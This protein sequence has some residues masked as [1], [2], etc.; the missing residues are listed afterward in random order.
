MHFV[1]QRHTLHYSCPSFHSLNLVVLIFNDECLTRFKNF[2]S[3]ILLPHYSL[4]CSFTASFIF[5]E[6]NCKKNTKTKYKVGCLTKHINTHSHVV[7][8][9]WYLSRSAS[10]FSLF[11]GSL[12]IY[13]Y[14]FSLYAVF[15]M[16]SALLVYL[17]FQ[18]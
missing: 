1:I 9:C 12:L 11:A 18:F 3:V 15:I 10:L 7:R 2:I 4:H 13:I 5:N 8:H 17:L 16:F 14:I 6:Y